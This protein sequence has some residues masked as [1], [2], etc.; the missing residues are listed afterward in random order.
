MDS[1]GLAINLPDRVHDC[2]EVGL[3]GPSV[4]HHPAHEEQQRRARRQHLVVLGDR[5]RAG[6]ERVDC[7][8]ELDAGPDANQMSAAGVGNPNLCTGGSS[9]SQVR[10][11]ASRWQLS[12][13]EAGGIGCSRGIEAGVVAAADRK[14]L[15]ELVLAR[16]ADGD[17]RVGVHEVVVRMVPQDDKH[18]KANREHQ[19]NGVADVAAAYKAPRRIGLGAI[20]LPDYVLKLLLGVVLV[21]R[22]GIVFILPTKKKGIS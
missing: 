6:N 4:R 15:D 2:M 18:G 16:A 12:P 22:G 7:F 21:Q 9:Q 17:L 20:D 5:M 3:A 11:M 14:R 13:A 10:I 1:L 8:V 19:A